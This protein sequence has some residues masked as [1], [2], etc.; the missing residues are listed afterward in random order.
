M[1]KVISLVLVSR[2]SIEKRFMKAFGNMGLLRLKF[3]C[4]TY[5]DCSLSTILSLHCERLLLYSTCRFIKRSGS[6]TLKPEHSIRMAVFGDSYGDVGSKT[7]D[8]S[9]SG[10][11]VDC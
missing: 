7:V 1:A 10:N 11:S 6:C 2:N 5:I 4:N 9:I 8:R 3:M